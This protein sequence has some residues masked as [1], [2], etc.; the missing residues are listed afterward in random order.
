MISHDISLIVNLNGVNAKLIYEEESI[1]T[2]YKSAY[3]TSFIITMLILLQFIIGSYFHKMIGLET[4]QIIQFFY[5]VRVIIEQKLSTFLNS[6]NVF[7]YTAYG[8]YTNYEA[9]YGDESE[10]ANSATFMTVSENFVTVGLMKRFSL[11]VNITL[12]LP[13]LVV[14]GFLIYLI[15][16][17][18]KRSQ[19]LKTLEQSEKDQYTVLRRLCQWFYDHFVFTYLNIFNMIVF[20]STILYLQSLPNAS[21]AQLEDSQIN[22]FIEKTSFMPHVIILFMTFF[23]YCLEVFGS[24]E[25]LQHSRLAEQ[26]KARVPKSMIEKLEHDEN[27]P[28]RPNYKPGYIFFYLLFYLMVEITLMLNLLIPYLAEFGVEIML[29]LSFLYLIFVWTWRPYH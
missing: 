27:N 3:I 20:F 21:S 14:V 25:E 10:E 2:A 1:L 4:I 16:K 6:M 8:G 5:F 22:K 12:V 18:I 9:V 24:Y 29:G 15:R 7:K 23:I 17:Y 26:E 28:D 13:A 19:Y 11:N